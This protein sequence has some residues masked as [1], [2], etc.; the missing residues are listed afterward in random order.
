MLPDV[1]VVGGAGWNP[2]PEV[3]NHFWWRQV[4][5]FFT[6]QCVGDLDTKLNMCKQTATEVIWITYH[7]T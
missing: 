2:L 3:W 1:V 6:A 7:V 4:S 5:V